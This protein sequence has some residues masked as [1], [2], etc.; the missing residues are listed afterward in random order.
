[1]TII[2]VIG[3]F[4]YTSIN[5]LKFRTLKITLEVTLFFILARSLPHLTIN[6]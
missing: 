4:Y 3:G 5:S 6:Y 2:I 1:M